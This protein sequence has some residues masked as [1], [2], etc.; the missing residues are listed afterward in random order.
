MDA[1]GQSNGLRRSVDSHAAALPISQNP[2]SCIL[3][4][5]LIAV[6]SEPSADNAAALLCRS[7]SAGAGPLAMAIHLRRSHRNLIRNAADRT[8]NK[9][10]LRPIRPAT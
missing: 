10:S 2:I 4:K 7:H 5:I 9:T 6:L 8:T 3:W 1:A